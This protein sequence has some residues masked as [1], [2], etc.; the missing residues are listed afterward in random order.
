MDSKWINKNPQ[1]L[2]IIFENGDEVMAGLKEAAVKYKLAASHFTAIGA[3][4]EVTLGFFDLATKSYKKTV[5]SE[6]LEVL[7][8]I[9]D[10]SL[11]DAEPQIHAHIVVGKADAT[12]RGGHFI[13]G[14]VRSTL[15]VIL[16]ESAT[17]LHRKF[18][19]EFGLAL[20]DVKAA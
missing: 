3:F 16:T 18:H 12:V 11:Q 2:A 6:Q 17:H 15:E 14:I 20:I 8:L 9:G 7:S 4:Q 1:T 10:I 19:P 13:S 5:I